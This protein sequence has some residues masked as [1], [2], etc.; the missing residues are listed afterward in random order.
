[1]GL[2]ICM[3]VGSNI[4]KGENHIPLCRSKRNHKT[5][6]WF[7]TSQFSGFMLVWGGSENGWT[8][9]YLKPSPKCG[10]ATQ[11]STRLTSPF[12]AFL[13]SKEAEQSTA[14]RAALTVFMICREALQ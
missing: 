7:S 2:K 14:G 13:R 11:F 10:F 12:P 8:Y 1:M 6:K 5:D 9:K 3:S 4:V